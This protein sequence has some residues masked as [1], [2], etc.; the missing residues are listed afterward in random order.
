MASR[1]KPLDNRKALVVD[2]E[3][4]IR[5]SLARILREKLGFGSVNTV[6]SGLEALQK[7]DR[8]TAL[9]V[10]DV[11]IP[12]LD[13]MEL[14]KILVLAQDRERRNTALDV[15]DKLKATFSA[16]DSEQDYTDV[17]LT[18]EVDE[19]PVDISAEVSNDLR[20]LM[21][22]EKDGITGHKGR[23]IHDA[24]LDYMQKPWENWEIQIRVR[25][26]LR[27]FFVVAG[28]SPEDLSIYKRE[29]ALRAQ[30]RAFKEY[31]KET[32]RDAKKPMEKPFVG[33]HPDPLALFLSKEKRTNDEEIEVS[34][35]DTIRIS[36]F[37]DWEFDRGINRTSEQLALRDVALWEKE[38]HDHCKTYGGKDY[39]GRT[40]TLGAGDNTL[41][42]Q[43]RERG[44]CDQYGVADKM[45]SSMGQFLKNALKPSKAEDPKLNHFIE[46]FSLIFLEQKG[47]DGLLDIQLG[48]PASEGRFQEYLFDV[49]VSAYIAKEGE[50][51]SKNHVMRPGEF[52]GEEIYELMDQEIELLNEYAQDP[53]MFFKK[54]FRKRL[55][56]KAVEDKDVD[57]RTLAKVSG[58]NV[59]FTDFGDIND[60]MKP[61][62]E[63]D[64]RTM[65][66]MITSCRSLAHV[67][68]SVY[69]NVISTMMLRLHPGG[70]I[71]ERDFRMSYSRHIRIGELMEI[72]KHF[73]KVSPGMFR[74]VA[75]GDEDQAKSINI[76]RG[77]EIE[78]DADIPEGCMVQEGKEGSGKRYIFFDDERLLKHFYGPKI[79]T[80][81]NFAKTWPEE[82][83]RGF[84]L[85]DVR[86]SLFEE[87]DVEIERTEKYLLYLNGGHNF[88]VTILRPFNTYGRKRDYHFVVEHAIMKML[89]EETCRMGDLS[90]TRD[91][92]YVDDHVSAYLTCLENPLAIGETFN[93]CTGIG[94][95][96]EKLIHKIKFLMDFEGEIEWGTKPKRPL[97]IDVLIGS[98]EKAKRVLGWQPQ[99]ILES[100]ITKTIKHWKEALE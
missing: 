24:G 78:A 68:D 40:C 86:K 67:S 75:T 16:A 80:I 58:Q 37:S 60:T 27:D 41:S 17:H 64:E 66:T 2:R 26:L 31:K 74:I 11:A 61:Q 6:K 35:Y 73:D 21:T 55:T 85:K 59:L 4:E 47:M 1:K 54:Y 34:G 19:K 56:D 25:Q 5:I 87:T 15:R 88:P 39:V 62:S 10:T 96:I 84:A 8:T 29:I 79:A 18:G 72:K 83:L 97:D 70:C 57:L 95:K 30:K 99:H 81:D 33:Y 45:Q 12:E 42:D 100:G 76:Q 89:T 20:I 51:P 3:E 38:I 36:P 52:E 69:R 23:Q 50:R 7:I 44:V 82:S 92:M 28:I 43:L 71:T 77:I 90:T 9:V 63:E 48:Y 32:S 91:F 46:V 14:A 53:L 22:A 49:D 93:F 94:I 13:G 65:F 98:Y